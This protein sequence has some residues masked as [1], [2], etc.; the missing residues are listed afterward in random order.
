MTSFPERLDGRSPVR[1]DGV[2]N[3]ELAR[4]GLR[5]TT[6]E[7][8]RVDVDSP[9]LVAG[10]HA[11]Y[12]AAGAELLLRIRPR[13]HPCDA[14]P[15]RRRPVRRAAVRGIRNGSKRRRPRHSADP[16]RTK[17]GWPWR[18]ECSTE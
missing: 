11:R 9:E 3:T 4:E 2:L 1:M 8:L 6:T 18:T 7:W 10:I 14:H 5:F 15:P 12:A 16:I 13:A 17:P